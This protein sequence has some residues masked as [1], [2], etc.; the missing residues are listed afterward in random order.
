MKSFFSRGAIVTS[1]CLPTVLVLSTVCFNHATLTLARATQR[2]ESSKGEKKRLAD[3]LDVAILMKDSQGVFAPVDP[4][5]EFVSGEQFRVEYASR[6]DGIVYFVN[7]DPGGRTSVIYRDEVRYGKK[8]VHPS[9]EEKKV[10]QFRG[11]SG[12]EVLKII[13]SPKEIRE[14]EN[15]L[16]E[17]GGKLGTNTQQAKE[18]LVGYVAPKQEPGKPCGGLELSSGGAKA[19]CR[20][21]SVV[22]MNQAQGK[23]SVAL[24]SKGD[25]MRP[26]SSGSAKLKTDEMAV[27]EIRLKHV[28]R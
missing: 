15:A 22:S 2:P 25:G 24:A 27:L 16:Q 17:S 7:V 23:I 9:P 13:I 4:S 10:I 26:N 20:E 1:F 6:L 21:L 5:R 19:G 3:G 18:E 12:I 14:L 28:Q 8:Y 11:N